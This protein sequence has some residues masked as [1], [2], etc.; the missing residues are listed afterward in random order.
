MATSALG[1]GYDKPDLA[2]CI[3]LGS[4][5][6]PVAYYQQVGRAGRALDDAL[7][8]LVPAESDERIWDY[9]ATAGIPVEAQVERILDVLGAT[10]RSRVPRVETATGI[11]RGPAGD[12]CSRSWPSTTR[13]SGAPDGWVV[14]R[15]AAG[16]STRPSGPRCA[17]SG[18][19]RPT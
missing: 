6:S 4:P 11:R 8:V 1:M 9:F 19:P 7:A 14:D 2:F 10:S 5:A 12:G 18:P 16:T 17:R 15:A 3:H 13:S